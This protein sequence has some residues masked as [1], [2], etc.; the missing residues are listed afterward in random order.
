MDQIEQFEKAAIGFKPGMV[1]ESRY[2]DTLDRVAAA[3]QHEMAI[4]VLQGLPG[5]VRAGWMVRGPTMRAESESQ[6]Q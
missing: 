4:W 3:P 6:G 2:R 5:T 1:G